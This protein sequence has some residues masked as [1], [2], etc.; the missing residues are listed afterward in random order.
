[1]QSV[2]RS[3]VSPRT[4]LRLA[5]ASVG[6]VALNIVSGAAV[7]L[8][9]SGLGCPD[10]PTCSR[11]SLTPPLSFHPV[12][13]FTNRAVVVL[14]CIGVA[15]ALGAAVARAPR[16]RDLVW[17]SGGLL[18]G[19]IGEAVLGG[20]VVYSHLN[21]YVVMVHFSVGIALLTDAV[22]LA[23][24]AGREPGTRPAVAKVPGATVTLAR[25]MLVFLA[26]AVVA[27][28][29]TTG[30]GP[31]AGGKGAKRIP[32]ALADM[33]RVHS[34]IVIV[35]VALAL[36]VLYR[37]ERGAAPPSVLARG[38]LLL[39]ATVVQG[40]IGYAQYFS[41]LPVLLVG[42]HVFGATLVWTAM[43]VFVDGLWSRGPGV[44]TAPAPIDAG[45]QEPEPAGHGVGAATVATVAAAPS[46]APADAPVLP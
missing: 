11:R 35:V 20:V 10:W 40:A 16:R 22:V 23:L 29:A 15:L 41:H 12:V 43:L 14:L 3:G 36:V 26:L 45:R 6:L 25:A 7:R 8:T 37:L 30:S 2:Q 21:P 1:V 13:E 28:T 5:Q 34:G 38:R 18:A 39:G 19:V 44:A 17:L 31:H 42:V 27:G 33:A 24:R 46:A 32:V 4:F 9:D